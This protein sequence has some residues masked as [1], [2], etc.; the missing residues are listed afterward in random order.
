LYLFA[1]ARQREARRQ[2]QFLDL[3]KNFGVVVS[4]FRSEQSTGSPDPTTDEIPILDVRVVIGEHELDPADSVVLFVLHVARKVETGF[5]AQGSVKP[6][7]PADFLRVTPCDAL[8]V[9]WSGKRGAFN[10]AEQR[11]GRR[12]ARKAATRWLRER[13]WL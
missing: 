6:K 8:I 10:D 11:H 7:Q 12:H 2:S 1:G 5:E 13:R 4:G 9:R 3:Q